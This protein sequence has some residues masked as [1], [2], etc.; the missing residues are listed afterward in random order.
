MH[1][2]NS[3]PSIVSPCKKSWFNLF[4]IIWKSRFRFY[5]S[6]AVFNLKQ[7]YFQSRKTVFSIQETTV[8]GRVFISKN[9]TVWL[10]QKK[11]ILSICLTK[12]AKNNA[13][14]RCFLRFFYFLLFF[15]RLCGFKNYGLSIYKNIP[16]CQKMKIFVV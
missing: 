1:D 10:Y 5:L 3:V 16:L 6:R 14:S 12:N 11:F 15:A 9:I 13:K 2:F 4:Y 8:F 7:W